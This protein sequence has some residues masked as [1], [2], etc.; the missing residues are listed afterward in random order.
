MFQPIYSQFA[1]LNTNM[2]S[3]FL[4]QVRFSDDFQ[5]SFFGGFKS[6]FGPGVSAVIERSIRAN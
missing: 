1:P 6:V 4:D 3:V 5:F 2:S